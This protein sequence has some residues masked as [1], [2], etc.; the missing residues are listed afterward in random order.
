MS[1]ETNKASV[2]EVADSTTGFEEQEVIG[3]FA[4][5]LGT[6]QLADGATWAR[7]LVFILKRREGVIDVDAK[8]AV[9]AMTIKDVWD[10]FADESPESGKDEAAS[11]QP[12]ESSLPSAS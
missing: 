8:A 6:L 11:E 7:A 10:T 4:Q 9:M 3:A 2:L 12:P 5:P 1:T